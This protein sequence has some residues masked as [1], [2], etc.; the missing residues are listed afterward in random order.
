MNR[1]DIK[2]DWELVIK[3]CTEAATAVN[4]L[5]CWKPPVVHRDLKPQNLLVDH[6]WAVKVADLGLARFHTQENSASLAKL[7]GTYL[8]AAPVCIIGGV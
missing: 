1:T 7:R 6:N 3:L 8:Y 2:Y 5:H 4:T